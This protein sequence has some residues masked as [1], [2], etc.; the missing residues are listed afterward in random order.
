MRVVAIVGQA[1]LSS[2]GQQTTLHLTL[3]ELL[4]DSCTQVGIYELV[5]H[6]LILYQ[7]LEATQ[8][9]GTDNQ[10]GRMRQQATQTEEV[11]A[12]LAELEQCLSLG[13]IRSSYFIDAVAKGESLLDSGPGN[14]ELFFTYP[15][16]A[17][18]P[19]ATAAKPSTKVS[20]PQPDMSTRSF[21][22]WKRVP[23]VDHLN[24]QFVSY[25]NYSSNYKS[26][27]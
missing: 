22:L 9:L 6:L 25:L 12:L 15:S 8:L 23:L 20:T 5:S 26:K 4:G 16:R 18:L 27:T 13:S 7:L 17:F 3:S 2:N 10:T 11:I 24:S 14:T 1:T 19:A 21:E